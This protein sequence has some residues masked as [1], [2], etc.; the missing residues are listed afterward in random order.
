[1]HD[2]RNALERAIHR[3]HA[4][5]MHLL[6]QARD[7]RFVDLHHIAACLRQ[8]TN[9][10][11]ERIGKRKCQRA[12]I[13]V[14]VIG[15]AVDQRAGAGQRHF[16]QS[17][18]KFAQC[19]KIVQRLVR[20]QRNRPGNARHLRQRFAAAPPARTEIDEIDI[21]KLRQKIT[22]NASDGACS[23]SHTMLMPLRA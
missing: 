8:R 22:E 15:H 2:N 12:F 16:D 19:V 14:I 5:G 7:R 13:A 9:F 11:I 4:P 6:R 10:F 21:V 20:A 1:M 18:G 17:M 23:P 3:L